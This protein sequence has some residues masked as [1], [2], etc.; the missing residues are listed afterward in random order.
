MFVRVRATAVDVRENSTS[1]VYLCAVRMVGCGI[2]F[3]E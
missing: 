2:L 3:A 1:S